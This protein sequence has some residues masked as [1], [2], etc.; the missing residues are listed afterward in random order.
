MNIKYP[1]HNL[2]SQLKRRLNTDEGQHD[3]NLSR[4]A[5]E[6]RALMVTISRD[7]RIQDDKKQRM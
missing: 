6:F 7:M 4:M 2:G 1:L 5:R 3:S